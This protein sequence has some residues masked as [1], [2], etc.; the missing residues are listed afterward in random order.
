MAFDNNQGET[1]II[2]FKKGR[3][4]FVRKCYAKN[5]GSLYVNHRIVY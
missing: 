2:F 4:N 5:K 3:M 1:N